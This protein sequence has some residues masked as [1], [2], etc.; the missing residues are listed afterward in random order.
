MNVPG[1]RRPGLRRPV[2]RRP[3]GGPAPASSTGWVEVSSRRALAV[4]RTLALAYAFVANLVVN[5]ASLASLPWCLIILV[6]MSVWTVVVSGLYEKGGPAG[7]R[8]PVLVADLVV[9]NATI[10]ATVL[11]YPR[12]WV[13]G[14]GLT[15]PALWASTV[16][17]AWAVRWRFTGAVV[18][19]TVFALSNLAV[20]VWALW[21]DG[22][23][24]GATGNAI[25]LMFMASAVVGYVVDLARRAEHELAE[26]IRLQGAA[27]ERERLSRQIHDGVL[28]V[29][30][31]VRRRG[32]E[33]DGDAAEIGRLAGEQEK[34][35]RT[36][37]RS[38]PSAPT[39]GLLD[40]RTS[41]AGAAH[42]PRVHL[43]SPAEAVLLPAGV[44]EELSAAVS[45]ALHNVDHHVGPDAEAWVLIEA[46]EDEVVV[47][48]RDDGPGIE[49]GRLTEAE[50]QGRI[51]IASSIV[52]RLRDIGG[53]AEIIS[54]PGQGTEVELHVYR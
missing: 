18:A 28:Q 50:A 23:V 51:G 22:V 15:V 25:A 34:A 41:L 4:F 3:G 30:A 48:I 54:A 35:L 20:T 27:A 21:P 40:L 26:A 8:W 38:A 47:T 2:L 32:A 7:P 16:A 45:A 10:V 43:V 53:R 46:T 29:L 14:G 5:P 44:A 1:L 12:E 49:P 6:A 19:S 17:L 31:M 33:L 42:G 39:D 36:L 37:I 11:A 13:A 24:T 52:G 9:T